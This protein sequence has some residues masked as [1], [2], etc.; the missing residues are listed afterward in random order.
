MPQEPLVRAIVAALVLLEE[1]GQDEIDRDT[2]VRG[3]ENIAHELLALRREDRAEFIAL[4][5]QIA[6][7]ETD[8]SYANFIRNIPRAIG[9][10]EA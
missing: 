2:A 8:V 4:I 5:E 3:M 7:A 9:M 6:D 10:V 1:S